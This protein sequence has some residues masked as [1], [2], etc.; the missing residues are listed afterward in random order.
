MR[1]NP[2]HVLESKYLRISECSEENVYA[3]K[4]SLYDVTFECKML[5]DFKRLSPLKNLVRRNKR[6]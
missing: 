2:R 1:R 3:V 4:I 5:V 6:P